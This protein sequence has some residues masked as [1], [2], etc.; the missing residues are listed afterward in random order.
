MVRTCAVD[1]GHHGFSFSR[2]SCFDVFVDSLLAV[3]DGPTL[4][5][6]LTLLCAWPG[7]VSHVENLPPRSLTRG[8]TPPADRIV[9]SLLHTDVDTADASSNS[10]RIEEEGRGEKEKKN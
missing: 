10:Y 3:S 2:I 6:T 7:E 5:A 4:P 8:W 9:Y 1:P